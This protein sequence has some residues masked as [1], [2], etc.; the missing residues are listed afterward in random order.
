MNK[1]VK[2]KLKVKDF[3]YIAT[4]NKKKNSMEN[5]IVSKKNLDV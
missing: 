5:F 4:F 2:T 3:S 1:K